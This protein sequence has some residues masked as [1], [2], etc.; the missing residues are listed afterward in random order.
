[1]LLSF[2]RTKR[3][4]FQLSKQ[5]PNRLNF[6]NGLCLWGI[7]VKHFLLVIIFKYFNIKL[8][9]LYKMELCEGTLLLSWF[10]KACDCFFVTRTLTGMKK[11]QVKMY[12]WKKFLCHQL[13]IISYTIIVFREIA[14]RDWIFGLLWVKLWWISVNVYEFIRDGLKWNS[15]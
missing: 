13:V 2:W 15:T 8:N 1:M 10:L 3:F 6:Q 4:V 7:Q 14:K 9:N 11:K 12:H 5:P